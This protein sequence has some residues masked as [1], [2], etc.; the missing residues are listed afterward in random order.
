MLLLVRSNISNGDKSN[1]VHQQRS[2]RDSTVVFI[3]I[4]P[5]RKID[6]E[7]KIEIRAMIRRGLRLVARIHN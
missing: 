2:R 4:Y 7:L 1:N 3:T 6:N 5:K